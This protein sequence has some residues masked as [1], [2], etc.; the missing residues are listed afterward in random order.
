MRIQD[1]RAEAGAAREV[2]SK[3]WQR[4]AKS[5]SKRNS[6]GPGAAT[7]GNSR[8]QTVLSLV[9]MPGSAMV[10]KI[11]QQT[12]F[13]EWQCLAASGNGRQDPTANETRGS[14]DCVPALHSHLIAE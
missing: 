9:A 7:A 14:A 6:F 5:D 1:R 4:W 10:G 8:K 2:A 11:R 3:H 13:F 12:G